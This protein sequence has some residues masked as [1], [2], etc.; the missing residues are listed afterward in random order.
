MQE[1]INKYKSDNDWLS[2]FFN[3]CCA[4]DP[5]LEAK[6]GEVYQAYRVYCARVG[7]FTR[8]TTEFYNAL[9]MRGITKRK[10]KAGMILTGL[11]LVPENDD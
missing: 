2:H 9:S 11:A 8:S 10:T 3:D 4:L 6:S 7:D 1:A 5:I